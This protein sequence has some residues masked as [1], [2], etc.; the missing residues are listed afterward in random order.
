[1][2]NDSQGNHMEQND[3]SFLGVF[4]N[5]ARLNA[6]ITLCHISDL[7][8]EKTVD[9]DSLAIMPVLRFLESAGDAVK[10][11]RTFELVEKHFPMLKV[12]YASQNRQKDDKDDLSNRAEAYKQILTRLLKELNYQRNKYCHAHPGK[13]DRDCDIETLI[14]YLDN[15]FDASVRSIKEKRK[16]KEEEVLHLRRF[17]K[18][19]G[20]DKRAD[21][22][23][24]HYHFKNEQGQ[25]SEKGLAFLAAMFLEK[26][27]TYLFLKKQHGFKRGETPAE[28]A[29]LESFCCYRIKLPKPVMTS[30]VDKNGLALDMLNELKKCPKELF[31]LLTKEKQQEFRVT[32]SEDTDEDGDEILMRRYSDRF[33]Y[34]ALR[35]CDENEVFKNMRFHIDL[36]RYYFKFYEKETIDGNKYQRALDKRLKTFGRI[37]D[38]KNKVK[39]EWGDIIKSPDE[40][41]NEQN[42][43]YKT[44]STPHYNLVDNQIGFVISGDCKLPDTNPPQEKIK[45]KKPDA[46][47][48]I[49]ELPG[50]LFYGLKCGFE[51]TERLIEQYIKRQI[52]ICNKICETGIIPEDAGE[53]LPNAIKEIETGNETK[54]EY[55]KKKLERMLKDTKNRIR[56]IKTTRQRAADESNKPGKK[57]FFDIRAGKL[58][59]FLARDIISLQKFDLAKKGKDKL[60]SIDFQV[61]QAALAYYGANKDTIADMFKRIGLLDGGN[62]HPFLKEID[63]G[64]C[65][66]IVNFYEAY[67]DRKYNYLKSCQEN[68]NLDSYQFLR[69]SLQRYAAGKRGLK[70]IAR[71]LLDNPVNI[72][73]GFFQKQIKEFVCNKDPA[74]KKLQMNTAYMIQAN[75]EK[76]YGGQQPF[77]S[78]HRIYP[79]VSKAQEY[80]KKGANEKIANALRSIS[81]QM[82]YREMG[83]FIKREI[84]DEGK[85][86]PENLKRN[87]LDGC[88]DFKNNERLLRRFKVQDMVAFMMVKGTLK[89]QL[90]FEGNV[91]IKLEDITPTKDSPF[92]VPVLCYTDITVPFNT[93]VKHEADY[94]KFIE[95]NYEDSY[96]SQGSRIIL[97]YR[98][99][100]ENTKLRDIG[101]YRRYFYDRR[102]PGLLIWKYPPNTEGGPEIKCAVIEEEIKAYEQHGPK[103]AK[104]L[105]S[106]EKKVIDCYMSK[107]ELGEGYI[108]FDEI[109]DKIKA[110]LTGFEEKCDTLLNIRNAINHNQFP[111]FMDAIEKAQGENIADKMLSI[112]ENYVKYIT[113]QINKSDKEFANV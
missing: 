112:T 6:Y 65:N 17:V 19:K 51:K 91:V 28:K 102:L 1:M 82:S 33:P 95:K 68:G 31:E 20:K 4:L 23:G 47:L 3:K 78:F 55:A 16:L 108:P 85:F 81:P 56:A 53:F 60:T 98:V 87:L 101:K 21:N 57:K 39:K 13:R 110:E 24:F 88:K 77:Y 27:D 36:G 32:V 18:G 74:L 42:E 89:E 54:N 52:K 64:K 75:F 70:T 71:Q 79:V 11:K 41:S 90:S 111:V 103:I 30:D 106:L 86:E 44:N 61:L 10:S 76:T 99:T 9:E 7:M 25:L 2:C 63:P 72:P 84:P 100:S 15:C 50:M 69:P 12:I 80:S 83:T 35:Y 73:K 46:W 45:L 59:D 97:K 67:L 8:G 14:R 38:V 48:S 66:S 113:E 94:V 34:L 109:T 58:A 22:P 92:N 93:K 62:P 40:I 104:Q 49:Y 96:S 5:Q 29:T 105:Y 37:K 43:P 26:K 107:D